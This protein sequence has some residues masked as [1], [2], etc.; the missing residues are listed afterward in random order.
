MDEQWM[1][2]SKVLKLYP[3]HFPPE[4]ITREFFDWA[5]D[6]VVSRCF[7]IGGCFT[8]MVPLGDTLNHSNVEVKTFLFNRRLHLTCNSEGEDYY[9]SCKYNTDLRAAYLG[10][11]LS[12]EELEIV[13]GKK[14]FREDRLLKNELVAKA[15]EVLA[16]EPGLQA[17][18]LGY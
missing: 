16:F 11:S 17:W 3:E 18:Q 7:S 6:L 5:Y 1:L 10:A 9:N 14:P 4:R 15:F 13:R 2:V 12:S 8:A